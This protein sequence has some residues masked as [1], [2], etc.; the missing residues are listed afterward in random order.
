MSWSDKYKRSINCDNPSG[1]SQKAHCAAR[2]KR[3]K[4]EETKSKSPFNEMHEVKSHK[5]VEQIA[6]KHR[7]EVSFIKNQL[8]MGVP[9]EHEHTKDKDLATDIALQHLDEIPDYYTR[10][11]KMEAEAKKEH[12]KF[13]DVPVSEGTLHHWF[14]GSKS[15][16]G[17]PG[18]VQADGSPCA[19]EPG[20]TK[21][22]KCFSSA[23]LASLKR[24]GEEGEALIKSAV[25]RKR[26]K[27]KGQQAKSGAAAPT[28]VPTFAKGKKDP[29]YIKA[30]PGIKEAMELNEAQKDQPG[31]GSG[32]KDACYHKVKAR[33]DVWP[34]AYASGALVKCRKVGAANWGTKSE[35]MEMMR[36]CPKCQKNETRDECKYG[37][38]YWDMYSLPM[39]LGKK[40]TPNTPHPGNFPESYDHEYSMARSELS[41]IIAAA[42]R[43]RKKMAKGE[44]EIE[45]WVQSK[46]TKAA[47]Y[48]DAAADY[49]D[50]GEMKEEVGSTD[51]PSDKKPFDVA[52]KKIMKKDMTTLQRIRALKQAGKLQG[53]DEQMLPPIDPKA[54]KDAQR[55][56]KL[57]NKG[58]GTDNPYEKKEFLKRTGPQLPL[59]KKDIKTQVAHYE[60]EGEI[61]DEMGPVI[62]LGIRAG[63]AAGTALA[64]K[65]VYD[66]AKGVADKIKERNQKMQR[67]IDQI[68]QS[69]EPDGEVIDEKCW[70]GYKK[71]GMKTMF[72]KRYP[73][74]V[75]AE[76]FSN[77]REEMGLSE[78][79]QKVNRQ[80]KTAGLSRAAVK[81]YRRENPG[82]KLQTAVTEKSPKGKRA[83]RR[84]SFC[85][86]MKGM[87]SKLTSAKT[88]R[89][90]DSNINKAL[91]RWN[92]N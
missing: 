59:A 71:K 78:D 58:A 81:A 77:W 43:L 60:P 35:A 63:L 57:Y 80:D 9:I 30:E 62:G 88:A 70:P 56:Q 21:T 69:Y 34:S 26:Q 13:K 74:C 54:H 2:K 51:T 66:K 31:K 89:D 73:N 90:P 64:G 6:K 15:K 22:P 12:K 14:K 10:L 27:D 79:W 37:A 25:R 23:R 11:K 20:E 40:Y 49:V 67:Q 61:I 33:Y 41:T 65:M 48:I 92:C 7:M 87:K 36:Y 29:N 53:V 76:G 1:F 68:N 52:V 47:D 44:G 83:K 28:N 18:W 5:T 8:K 4:G 82:S 42:K 85:R 84:A 55:T 39:S 91:R 19:N 17:K 32:S 24:K 45:A 75:K 16:D 46:I 50:S 3:Q 38:N 72:G 86:R